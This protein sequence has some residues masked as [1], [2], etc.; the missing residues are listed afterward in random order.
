MKNAVLSLALM[1]LCFSA[2]LA[3][4]ITGKW[5]GKFNFVSPEGEKK[6]SPAFITINNEQ[7]QYTATG[8]SSEEQQR[9]L[10]KVSFQDGVLRFEMGDSPTMLVELRLN[11]NQLA[12]RGSASINGKELTAEWSLNRK[13]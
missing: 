10:A 8:G 1:M 3:Q 4:D 5:A 12:G 13:K 9:P 11:G 7:G 6:S 2:G